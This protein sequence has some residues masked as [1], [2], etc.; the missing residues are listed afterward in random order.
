MTTSRCDGRPWFPRAGGAGISRRAGGAGTPRVGRA[1]TRIAA[2]AIAW[3]LALGPAGPAAA[4]EV[5][6]PSGH[7]AT[8]YDV[9][10]EPE[11]QIARFRFLVPGLGAEG[12][13]W[14]EMMGDLPWL[15]DGLALPALAA[16]GWSARQVVI[17]LSDREV[18]HGQADPEAVQFFEGFA[19][20]AERCQRLPF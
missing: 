11:T 20:E 4:Q 13:G 14:D 10:I 2:A 6:L 15:C 9:V 18:P 1:P 12:A 8:L 3:G 5:E 17:V 19:L 16:N 7:A